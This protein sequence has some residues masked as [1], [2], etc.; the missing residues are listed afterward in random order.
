MTTMHWHTHSVWPSPPPIT[1]VVHLLKEQS[2]P[3]LW[4]RAARAQMASS[5]STDNYS[6]R[7]SASQS[8]A[9]TLDMVIA[10]RVAFWRSAWR[11]VRVTPCTWCRRCSGACHQDCI[12]S[13]M[14]WKQYV[15]P[16]PV[17]ASYSSDPM[18][19]HYGYSSH[20]HSPQR[21]EHHRVF[22][23]MSILRRYTMTQ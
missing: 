14:E 5:E 20:G 7:Y 15:A 2:Q 9:G 1:S 17:Y 11:D 10:W 21:H 3:L 18:I 4:H 19:R 22:M 6:A 8:T 13:L 16:L 23:W 12:A